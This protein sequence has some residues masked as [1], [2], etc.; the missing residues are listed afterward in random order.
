[1]R[2]LHI[3]T[4]SLLAT[5]AAGQQ[6]AIFSQF[7]YNKI[8][9]NP[10][11]AGSNGYPA[12]AAFHRQQWLGLEGAPTSQMLSFQSPAFGSR[13]GL[14]LSLSSDRIGFFNT[15]SATL[16]YAYRVDFGKG[17][18][19]IG[20]QGSY[21]RQQVDWERARTISGKA[22]PVQDGEFRT[23]DFNVGAGAHFEN[24]RFFAGV[25]VPALL[26]RG[27]SDAAQVNEFS[28]T[29]PHFFAMAGALLD[30]SPRIKMRPGM[31]LRMVKNAPASLDAHLSFGFLRET[32]LWLGGTLRLSK[33]EASLAGD[34]LVATAQYRIG[35]KLRAGIAYDLALSSLR[36]ENQGTF[37]LMLEY[38]LVRPGV[39]VRN[40]RFF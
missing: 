37:E 40:P 5:A 27:F 16:A 38:Q 15:S 30:V 14:G 4:F 8:Q 31:A 24:E 13:V 33:P 22:D 28:G 34:A 7:F 9:S 32:Q 1:M 12:L 10:G 39:A 36:R 18:L 3:F 6:Q 20:V 26:E 23:Q 29:M 21:L 19:G 17:K 2:L 25:S 35:E 11:A